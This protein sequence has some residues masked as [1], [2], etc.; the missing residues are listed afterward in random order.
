MEGGG[1]FGFKTKLT[2]R[3]WHRLTEV[4]NVEGRS[5]RTLDEFH[6]L[7]ADAQLR[8]DRG[9]FVARWRRLVEKADGPSIENLGSSPERTAQGYGPEIRKRLE[10][11]VSVWEPL[12][13][14]LGKIGFR[15]TKWLDSHPPEPG[16][17]GELARVRSACSHGLISIIEAQAARLRQSELSGA[18]QEQR[19]H[20]AGFPQSEIVSVLQQAQD[21]WNVETYEESCR[22]LARLDGLRNLYEKRLALLAKLK[23]TAPAWAH[24]IAQRAEPHHDTEPPANPTAA[25]RWRQWHQELERRAAISMDELQDRLYKMELEVPQLSARIIE[26]ETWAAQCD[27]TGLEQ[28]Q[29]LMG[30]VQTMKKVGKGTGKRAPELLRQA[31]Q[32]LTRARHAV[33]VWIMPLSRVYESFNPRETKFDVVIIDE[34][35]QSDV[36]ALA[37]LYLGR[38]HIVVGDKEQVTPDAI[39]QRIEDVQRLIATDLQSIPNSHLYD[40]QTSIYDLAESA[41]GGVVALREHFRC[42]PEIIQ[43]SNHLSY[44]NTIRPLREPFSASVRPALVSQR[45]NGQRH[46]KSNEVE[47]EE[48]VSLITACLQDPAY[49][50][51]ESG[52]PTSFG[53]ISLLGDEQADLIESK[54]RERLALDVFSKHRLLCGNAAQ[55]QGDERDVVFLSMVDGPP[56]DGKLRLR[57]AGPKD[58]YKKRYNV[59][60]SRARNQLWVIHS[61]DPDGHLKS[62]DLRRRLIGH[63]R[64]PHALLRAMEEQGRQTESEFEKRVLERLLAAGYRVRPQWPVG[65]YRIDLV[66]DGDERRLAVECDGERW[67]T[68][69][70]LQSDLERQAV[71]QRLGWVFA[72]I[73]GSLFFR[74]PDRAMEPV[75][76]KLERLG[77]KPLGTVPEEVDPTPDIDRLRRRAEILRRDW[78]EE[79]RE[80]EEAGA[81]F[82]F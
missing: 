52:E 71:L 12:I 72:R 53:V 75:F 10:W 30:F 45:V 24:A 6:A 14:E 23:T 76:A 62:G 65:A 26:D 67:H 13:D 79:T 25:W 57:D 77:I 11:R 5:P 34:A 68:S 73:R 32:L 9:R 47:A 49:A 46:G 37:A 41:F 50:N 80:A 82:V 64:D 2:K 15:W 39:G 21:E 51:N 59:A 16:D 70:Q 55:F 42:V 18:L 7:R 78:A 63:A 69:E 38:T 31:R 61:L 29:A 33:P 17:H 28:Q 36:T 74:D 43:F 58:L 81:G 40:G 20:L 44:S 54:L 3:N 60:V 66:V 56:D 19:T 35:S 48:I 8:Q 27:R 1:S 4:C 22:E